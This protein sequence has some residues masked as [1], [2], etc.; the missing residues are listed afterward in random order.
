MPRYLVALCAA[1]ATAVPAAAAP[2]AGSWKMA[3][4]LNEGAVEITAG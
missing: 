4:A 3:I 2:P 1:L